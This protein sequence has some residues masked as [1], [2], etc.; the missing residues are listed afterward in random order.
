M[1]TY[2]INIAIA[3]SSIPR[4]Q[5]G[6]ALLDELWLTDYTPQTHLCVMSLGC[7]RRIFA[8]A[9]VERL[10]FARSQ[11][12]EDLLLAGALQTAER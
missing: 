5:Q 2:K 3:V 1:C 11:K 8:A 7:H 4:S 12:E 6:G 10:L 9:A